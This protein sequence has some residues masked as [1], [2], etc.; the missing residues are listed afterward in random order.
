MKHNVSDEAVVEESN[1]DAGDSSGGEDDNGADFLDRFFLGGGGH[2]GTRE[3]FIVCTRDPRRPNHTGPLTPSLSICDW[4]SSSSSSCHNLYSAGLE[5][6]PM[7]RHTP[8][9]CAGLRNRRPSRCRNSVVYAAAG[10][11]QLTTPNAAAMS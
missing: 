11:S 3:E 4:A 7:S 5:T 2:N 8:V 10:L 1:D 9:V 6:C